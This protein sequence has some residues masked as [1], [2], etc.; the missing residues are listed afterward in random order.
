MLLA[1]KVKWIIKEKNRTGPNME[2]DINIVQ[3]Y[4]GLGSQLLPTYQSVADKFGIS[5]RE[6]V[7]QIINGKFR[8]KVSLEDMAELSQIAN[9]I[10]KKG[11]IFVDELMESLVESSLLSKETKI[12]GLL[13]LLHTF[14]LCKEFELYN[15]DLRKPTNTDIEEGKQ[16]LLTHEGEQK[17][18]L[19]MYQ[20]IKTYPGMHGICNLYDVFENE[21]L[22]GSYLPII[23]K[24]ISHSEYSWVNQ[25]NENQ[26]FYLFENRSNVIKNM[27]GKTCNITKN[28]PIY[29]LV[30][31][32]YKYISKRTLTLEPPSKEIIEIYIHN[33]TYMSIQGG[34]AFL[35]LE[36]KKLDLI[37]KDI[38]DFYKNIGRNT[39][40]Y[41][42]VRSYLE[43]KEYT[44]AYY[45]K[46]LFSSP[47]IYID[48]SKGR[49]NYQ[50][51][52]VSNFNESSTNDKMIEYSLY[53]D[54]LKELNG[55]TDKPY[56]EM[57]RQEQQILRNMLFKN[58]NTE[59]CAICGRKFSVRSLVAAHKKKRKDC[60]ESERTDPHIVFPL[61]LF[62]CDYLYEEG[63]IRI[64]LG[65]V[66]IEPN[67]D[68]QETEIDY[69]NVINGNEIAKRWQLG[70][71]SYFLK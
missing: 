51:I 41:T 65:E 12:V 48:E 14:N 23:K 9:F 69:L 54:K 18:L 31:L 59:T 56:N 52:L 24:L 45:D 10:K 70:E 49:G 13:Q 28:I 36:P 29:I 35:D 20:R 17:L 50:F 60:S 38:L 30:E 33:S 21:N 62:G 47:F 40:T 39:I 4:Y 66:M 44:K 16:L 34:N 32:I 57:V 71:E 3:T 6:R 37:E 53:K 1:D 67:N 7:R 8:D 2:R 27:L 64:A 22:N 11:V 19:E 58:K 55:K 5:S 46:V 43:R 63:N 26:Y 25:S 15:V 61:C 42:E 68:L